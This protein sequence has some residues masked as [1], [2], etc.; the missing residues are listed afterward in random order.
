MIAASSVA[1]STG[2]P[3]SRVNQ[4]WPLIVNA[5]R[6]RGIDSTAVEQA[7]IATVGTEVPGFQLVAE[8]GGAGDFANRE[9]GT[10]LGAALG[11]TEAGDGYRYRGRGWLQLT[12]RG[13]YRAAGNAIGSNLENNPDAALTA[14]VAADVLAWYF[15]TRGVASAAERGDWRAVRRLVNGGYN[16]WD[17]FTDVLGKL[18]IS[19]SG[20]AAGG[21][22]VLLAGGV[23]W[24]MLRGR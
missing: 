19:A 7:V 22:G 18:G 2:A 3:A 21:L 14:P 8:Y 4:Y 16:G 11:N 17:R 5:L 1:D 20:A 10:K 9:P 13:N 6:K 12:G 15:D 23:A 24:L